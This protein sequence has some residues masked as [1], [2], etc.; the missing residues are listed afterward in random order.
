MKGPQ[1]SLPGSSAL[2]PPQP[3]SAGTI[4]TV[5]KCLIRRRSSC[6]NF[7]VGYSKFSIDVTGRVLHS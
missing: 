3:A 7:R 6:R 2:R 4:E 1:N 5:T